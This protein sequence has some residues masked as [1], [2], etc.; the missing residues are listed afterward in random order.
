MPLRAILFSFVFIFFAFGALVEPVFG[1]L[2][3]MAHYII[4]AE[5][6][7]WH[8][9]LNPLGIRYSLSFAVLTAVGIMLNRNK[10]KF[11]KLFVRQEVLA[12]VMLLWLWVLYFI[13]PETVGRY[14]VTDHPTIKLTKVMIFCFM[15]THV[16]TRPKDLDK[17]MWL[18][19]VGS[20]L[21]GLQAYELPR[22]AFT[23]GRLDAVVGGSDFLDANAL[24]AFMVAASVIA[25]TVFMRTSWIGKLPCAVA[26]AFSLNTIV[27]CRSRGA[28]LAMFA[29][30]VAIVFMAPRHIRGKLIIGMIVAALAM[31]Y[32]SDPQFLDRVA[33]IST[34]VGAVVEGG[35]SSD[36]STMMRIEAW[37][38][39]IQMFRDHPMGVGPGNFNQYIGRYAPSV[40]GLSP[41]SIY[42]QTLA[43]L[44]L[45]GMLVLL[46]L[47]GNGLWTVRNVI[48]IS[49]RLSGPERTML[50]WSSC[51]VG[52]IIVSYATSGLTANVLYFEGYWWFLLLPVCLQRA[53][54]NAHEAL[55]AT[56]PDTP[57]VETVAYP[58][59]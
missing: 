48:R 38:G 10:L 6:Q 43:E 44:G 19:V 52:A 18:F 59:E 42:V 37:R 28:L 5:R 12:L 49:D 55:L 25:G 32:L 47:L 27:L 45:P 20:L 7:W 51:G 23:S 56:T 2:G 46:A 21:L 24:A 39:G 57:A 50:Q 54:E 8:A 15:M 30:G 41:H 3:Y 31:L 14:V 35:E 29:A 1:I 33:K 36:R 17:L 13:N 4:G 16:I 58:K 11:Q 53:S 34:H 22:S 40:E 26:G 9:P